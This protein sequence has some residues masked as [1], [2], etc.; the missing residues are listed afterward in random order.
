[1]PRED[2]AGPSSPV[3]TS[4]WAC[5]LPVCCYVRCVV[6][7]NRDAKFIQR[8]PEIDSAEPLLLR[9][10]Q[11]LRTSRGCSRAIM[12]QR[13]VAAAMAGAAALILLQ[14]AVAFVS[15]P[16][17]G[18]SHLLPGG[19]RIGAGPATGR[20]PLSRFAPARSRSR[21]AV[22]FAASR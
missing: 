12:H 17:N 10:S 8:S 11:L 22:S 2:P 18:G 16:R 5:R 1:M 13:L 15:C 19:G 20:H 6:H 4:W 9:Y 14:C 3:N 7:K 21:G